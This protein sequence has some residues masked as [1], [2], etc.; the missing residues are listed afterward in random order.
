MSRNLIADLR[1][2][3]YVPRV[4]RPFDVGLV[5]VS[6]V[7]FDSALQEV[8]AS[9][10]ANYYDSRI[11]F[12]KNHGIS[13]LLY[14]R[15][16]SMVISTSMGFLYRI[17]PQSSGPSHV[18]E[19]GQFHPLSANYAPSLFT[20]AGDRYLVGVSRNMKEKKTKRKKGKKP[21][22]RKHVWV[23]YDLE[24]HDSQI[25]D[26]PV[27]GQG[28]LIYGSITRDL[29]GRFY[30]AGQRNKKPMLLQIDPRG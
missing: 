7:E 10:L 5:E 24:S 23:V 22:K 27:D 20:F 29:A 16:E 21:D 30:V 3:V 8:G 2:N 13:G 9:V 14:L 19:L 18:K 26:F 11:H 1:G 17:T 15:D 6:L 12:N 4:S 25:F 28:L